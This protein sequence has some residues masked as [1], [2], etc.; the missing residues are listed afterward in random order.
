MFDIVI[1]PRALDD[2]QVGIDYYD[3]IKIGLGELFYNIINEYIEA[4]SINPFYQIRYKDY[5]A[6]PIS[7]FP[8]II[9]FYLDESIKT[10]YII[11]IFN[12]NQNPNN[13]PFH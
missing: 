8:Y 9:I 7:K 13:Y 12:T 2:I 4:I 3:S 5:R 11:S 10:A 6:L 1:E